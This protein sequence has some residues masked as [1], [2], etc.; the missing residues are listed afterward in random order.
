MTLTGP[1]LLVALV[2]LT[3]AVL[4]ATVW[5]WRRL[6]RPG[7]WT[8]A[9]RVAVVVTG[10]LL[11]V[12]VSAVALNDYFL[13]FTDWA[14]LFG[15]G[16]TVSYTAH[17]GGTAADLFHH[18]VGGGGPVLQGGGLHSAAA[19]HLPPLPAGAGPGD[20]QLNYVV[21]GRRSGLHGWVVVILP[22]TY[23]D[24]ASAHRSYPVIE[25]FG[26]YPGSNV[27]LARNLDLQGGLDN[28]ARAGRVSDAIVVIPT[29]EFPAGVDTE[30]VNGPAGTPQVE[31]WAAVDV[32]AWVRSHFRVDRSRTSWS[33]LGVSEGGYCSAMVAMRHPGQFAAAVVMGGYF[34]PEWGNWTPFA[35]HDPAG[36]A[37]DLIRLAGAAPPPVAMWVETSRRDRVSYPSTAAMLR[38]VRAPTVMESTVVAAGGHRWSQWLPFVA[39]ALE[40]L[41]R[42][43]PGFAPTGG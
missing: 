36:A 27:G 25:A 13:F 39:P 33:T 7:P 28:A 20:R 15:A 30:C 2:S 43:V 34:R 4:V 26:G 10:N 21:T 9:G 14:D 38:S 40:W 22:R 16:S 35:P 8:V 23:F 5:G 11:V 12:A 19:V 18:R 24:A 41:G 29:T 6:A 3:V 31:T 1:L 32:P 37:Y 42:T 17:A